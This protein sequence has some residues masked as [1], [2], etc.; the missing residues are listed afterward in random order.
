MAERFVPAHPPRGLGPVAGWRGLFGE[1]ARTSVY[2]WSEQAFEA[3]SMKRRIFGL[4]VYIPSHP[5]E[6]Q[7]VLL[8]NAANYAKPRLVKRILAPTIGRGLLTSDGEL[9]RAQRK[10]VAASFTPPAVDALVPVFAKTGSAMAESWQAGVRD[11]AL[12]ATS[13][14]MTVISNALFSGDARLTSREAMDHITAAMEGV[15]EARLQV[16]LGMPLI[17]VTPSGRRGQRGQRY[18]RRT[19]TQLVRERLQPDAPEDF[20]T[21]VTRALIERFPADEA[22]ELAVDNAATFYLAGHETTANTTSWTLY[23]LS[24]QPELQEQAAA[25]ARS[26]LAAG[27]DAGLPDRLPL[28]RMILEESLRLYPP[29]P[30]LDREALAADRLGEQDVRPG[31]FISIWPWIIH[32]HKRLWEDADVFDATRFAPDRKQDRNRFQYLPFGAGPRT[33]VGA[34]LAMAEALTILAIWL[35]KWRFAPSPGRVVQVS[36]MVTLRPK[37]GLPLRLSRR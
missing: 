15:A 25:E 12:E 3:W 29:V 9:W 21:N 27:V 10:I 36:G 33:C 17:P 22:I 7:R 14:T 5:E 31:D 18:L 30:R 37:G 6:V 4:N 11:M 35:S 23:L 13:A 8:D 16:L 1:R 24:E 26:A 20:V 19:L 32:R 34:R 28:L 2:G